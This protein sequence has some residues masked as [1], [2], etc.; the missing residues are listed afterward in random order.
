MNMTE[1]KQLLEEVAAID[2]REIT[3]EVVMAWNGILAGMSLEIAREAHRLARRD[4]KI[5]WL[6]PKNIVGW[7]KEAAYRLDREDNLKKQDSVPFA[8]APQPVCREHGKK[9]MSCDKCCD[10]MYKYREARGEDT[11]LHFAKT[12]IYA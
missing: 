12:K 3:P 2:N 11:L 1:T 5:R 8:A 4:E 9:I 6:E 10:R 7:A